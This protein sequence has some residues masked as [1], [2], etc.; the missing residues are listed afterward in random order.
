MCTESA[1]QMESF[2]AVVAEGVTGVG[3]GASFEQ[4]NHKSD[5]V[6]TR[7]TADPVLIVEGL[8]GQ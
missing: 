2:M 7:H 3:V 6:A 1:R 5:R 4:L 8:V